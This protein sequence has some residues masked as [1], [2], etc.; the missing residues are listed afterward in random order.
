VLPLSAQ[1][2]SEGEGQRLGIVGEG[3]SVGGVGHRD[4]LVG[5]DL[6]GGQLERGEATGEARRLPGE[7]AP[8]QVVHE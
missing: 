5:H 6:G 3:E 4:L 8:I 2:F 1:P 7:G